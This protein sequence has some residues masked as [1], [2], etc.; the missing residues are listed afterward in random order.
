MKKIIVFS[1]LLALLSAEVFAQNNSGWKIGFTAQ[2]TRD[3]FYVSKASGHGEKSQNTTPREPGDGTDTEDLGKFIKGTANIFTYTDDHRPDNRLIISLSNSGDHHSVYIDAK[4][5]DRWITADGGPRFINLLS[6][7][8]ADWWF[9]GDTGGL[10]NSIVVFDG[11]VGTGGYGGFVPAYELWDDWLQLNDLNFFGIYTPSGFYSSNNMSNANIDH[12][13]WDA[14][15][16]IGA[17]FI[18]K[19]R[20]AMGST[21][22]S[23]DKGSSNPVASASSIEAGFM[24]SGKDL[25]PITFDVFY[26]ISGGDNNTAIRGTW[27]ETNDVFLGGQ[28]DNLIGAYVG[29]DLSEI[30]VKGLGFSFGYTIYFTKFE[31]AHEEDD[32]KILIPYEIVNPLWSGIDLKVK[33]TGIENLGITFNNN[34]SFTRVEGGPQRLNAGDKL[35]LGLN[36]KPLSTSNSTISNNESWFSYAAILGVSYAITDRLNATFA[37]GNILA[38]L[39]TD[40]ETH[41]A[42]TS[43]TYNTMYNSSLTINNL[44]TSIRAEYTAG[45]VTVG[46]G[47]NIGVDSI[48]GKSEKVEKTTSIGSNWT[49]TK[50]ELGNN[51]IFTFSVPIYFKVAI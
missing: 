41:D 42:S 35:I 8:N 36:Y 34:F 28:W 4:I 18:D 37:L 19:I 43:T 33:F 3:F 21:L 39:S 46:L 40:W 22:G 5:D 27:D 6:G 32:Y 12:S 44:F 38:V 25:G 50:T 2:L 24:L 10:K 30:G 13:P 11:K 45:N 26:A 1:V 16:A 9:S 48:S 7:E 31:K 23:F 15:Y 49:Q 51:N 29:L 20:F 14:V 17:T 47:F